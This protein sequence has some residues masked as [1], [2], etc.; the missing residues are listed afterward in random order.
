MINTTSIYIIIGL[1]AATI[2]S[3]V[4]P[5]VKEIEVK[6]EAQQMEIMDL[7]TKKM[8]ETETETKPEEANGQVEN[9]IKVN[10]CEL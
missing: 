7:E 2:W 9:T 6:L 10:N 8:N 4:L 3:L 5:P 1:G